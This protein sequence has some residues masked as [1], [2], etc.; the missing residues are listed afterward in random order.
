M[1]D[2]TR[3]CENDTDNE[4]HSPGPPIP[5][6]GPIFIHSVLLYLTDRLNTHPSSRS[7]F[8]PAQCWPNQKEVRCRTALILSH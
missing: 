3:R 6:G 4:T 1:D 7:R 2:P 8:I 5:S